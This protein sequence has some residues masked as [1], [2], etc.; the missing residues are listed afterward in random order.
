MR[1]GTTD[2]ATGS[3]ISGDALIG[4]LIAGN[5]ILLPISLDPHGRW[6][7]MFENFLFHNL[8]KERL[9]FP[10]DWSNATRMYDMATSYPCPLGIVP[11][12][13]VRWKAKKQEILWPLLHRSYT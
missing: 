8:P 9:N 2:G 4:E 12:A 1:A 6:G 7:P 11:T 5:T 13:S 10:D 3:K